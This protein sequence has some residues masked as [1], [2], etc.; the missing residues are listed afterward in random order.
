MGTKTF[1]ELCQKLEKKY[2]PRFAPPSC[3]SNG[4]QGRDLYGRF[5]PKKAA[6]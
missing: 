2:G 5:P 3:C 1:V 4:R 6:A